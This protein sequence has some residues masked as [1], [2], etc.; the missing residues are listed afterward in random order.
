MKIAILNSFLDNIGGAEIVTLTMARE[1]NADIYTTNINK[2]KIEK[3][4]FIDVI[5]RIYSIG[6]VPTQAP[7][8]HQLTFWKFRYLNLKEKYDFFIISGDW[9]MSGAVNNYPNLWYVHSPLNELWE[10]K[11]WIKKNV[12]SWWKKPFYEIFVWINRKLTLKYAR[13]V[14]N[15][16]ANSKNVKERIKKYYNTDSMIIYPP[17]DTIKYYWLPPKDYWLSVNRLITHKRIELQMN[18]FLKLPNEKLIIVGSYEK[19]IIQFENYKKY[20]E[21]ICPKNVQIVNWINNKDL[22][23]LYAECKGFITTAKNEDLGMTP[24][25]AMASGKPVIAPNEGGYKETVINKETGILI[26][27]ID[28]NQLIDT[29]KI[30]GE[31]SEKYKEKCQKQVKKFDTKIF[32]EKINNELRK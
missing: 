23:K 29:I 6:K 4:G 19:G 27:N 32:I 3:M 2:E 31:N 22:K 25:E 14:N 12:L 24:I 11:N 30:V 28:F 13:S 18:A 5:P 16:I 8:K 21:K 26:N 7:F 15:F 1:F 9:A 10:F 17:I 20:I